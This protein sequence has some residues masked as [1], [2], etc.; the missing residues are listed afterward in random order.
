LLAL[1]RYV[2][3]MRIIS[4]ILGGLFMAGQ[5]MASDAFEDFS[6]DVGARWDYVADSVMGGVSSGRAEVEKTGEGAVLRLHGLVSTKN[7]GGFIQVRRRFSE[8]W[9]DD[10]QGLQL[11]VRG[12]GQTY[13]VFLKTPGLS[14]VWYS[15]RAQFKA[16]P[17]W[18]DVRLGFDQF[19]PSHTAMPLKF[20]PSD[21]TSIA[22]VGYGA[23]FEADVSVDHINIY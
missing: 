2:W 15:Y 4:S 6:G 16:T 10:A 9:S 5:A 22:I 20:A 13:Y 18:Q 17:E 21:V 11:R 23:D 12:N 8:P 19:V 14:R 3:I 7:N 1:R